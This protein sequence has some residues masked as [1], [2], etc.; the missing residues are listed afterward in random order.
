MNNLIINILGSGSSIGVPIPG[1]KCTTCTSSNLFNQRF[2]TSM[3]V[4][5]KGIKFLIDTSPE[6]KMQMLNNNITQFDFI[7]YTH[8]HADHTKGIDDIML[9]LINRN[10]TIDI[11]GD[12][13]TLQHIKISSPYLFTTCINPF[14]LHILDAKELKDHFAPV[15]DYLINDY[16]ILKFGDISIQT[17]VQHHGNI[18]TTGFLFIDKKFAYSPDFNAL[19][20]RSLEILKNAKL[21]LWIAPLTNYT[22]SNKH[23]GFDSLLK[24]IKIIAPKK[25]LFVHMS[26]F[27]EYDDL[28]YKLS[29]IDNCEIEIMPAYDT[30]EIF[31]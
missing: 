12:A 20:D 16:D 3:L 14:Q 19:T 27:V 15:V 24:L 30:M 18:N 11:Y 2:R 7:L 29:Q 17:F 13:L 10:K 6:L 21:D 31:M 9:C 26:H 1:C 4:T 25:V 23:I 5:Y 28:I 22:E 8:M